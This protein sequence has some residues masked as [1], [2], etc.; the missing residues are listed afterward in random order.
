MIVLAQSSEGVVYANLSDPYADRNRNARHVKILFASSQGTRTHGFSPF[1]M[2][3]KGV[4]S[5]DSAPLQQLRGYT[6]CLQ[7]RLSYI[8]SG[9][10][11]PNFTRWDF[12][13]RLSDSVGYK[14]DYTGNVAFSYTE[15]R[16]GLIRR[17]ACEATYIPHLDLDSSANGWLRRRSFRQELGHIRWLRSCQPGCLFSRSCLG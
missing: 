5:T 15:S 11:L 13:E 4:E 1:G 9:Y 17:T 7:L 14:T 3:A 8:S 12:Y 2:C 6:S 16:A 10:F